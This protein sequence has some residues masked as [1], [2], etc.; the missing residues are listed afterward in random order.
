MITNGQDK[1]DIR[2]A[3][4]RDAHQVFMELANLCND[5]MSKLIL[6]CTGTME[7][8][9]F[10]GAAKAHERVQDRVKHEATFFME[11]V[12]EKQLKPLLIKHGFDVAN[13]VCRITD[14][15]DVELESKIKIDLALIASDKYKLSAEYIKETYGSNVTETK[16]HAD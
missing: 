7:D 3:S 5:E 1:L 16:Q 4:R 11:Q 12:I 13:E 15:T 14:N 10:V 9:A 6:G 2:E 8:K